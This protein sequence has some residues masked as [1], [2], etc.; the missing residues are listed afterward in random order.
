MIIAYSDSFNEQKTA[1]T[2]KGFLLNF[3]NWQT[4]MSYKSESASISATFR[5]PIIPEPHHFEDFR[6][7]LVFQ[8]AGGYQILLY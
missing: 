8:K 7:Q 1:K 5:I 6:H 2:S 4:Q 3:G